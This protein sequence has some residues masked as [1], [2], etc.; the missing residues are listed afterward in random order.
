MAC[1]LVALA[2]AFAHGLCSIRNDLG[3][4]RGRHLIYCVIVH[5]RQPLDRDARSFCDAAR[6]SEA[7]GV[8]RSLPE[9]GRTDLGGDDTFSD[10]HHLGTT[11]LGTTVLEAVP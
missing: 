4:A 11:I 1:S 2:R 7:R 8:R 9:S 10:K 6:T 5:G 3:L